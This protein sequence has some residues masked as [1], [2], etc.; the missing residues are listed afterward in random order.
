MAT[1]NTRPLDL[2]VF[3]QYFS[4]YPSG[5]SA[6]SYLHYFQMFSAGRF[7]E[8]DHGWERNYEIYGQGEPPA[9]DL[10]TLSQLNVPFAIYVGNEDTIVSKADS[11]RLYN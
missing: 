9:I 11:I 1:T 3:R 10:S 6:N 5:S 7:K 4:H 2:E 8:F